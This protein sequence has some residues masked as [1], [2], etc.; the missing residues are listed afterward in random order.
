VWEGYEFDVNF[1]EDYQSVRPFRSRDWAL[2][3]HMIDLVVVLSLCGLWWW[4]VPKVRKLVFCWKD[5]VVCGGGESV[6][7]SGFG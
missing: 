2:D 4:M 1:S 5:Y 6:L 3:R 7:G